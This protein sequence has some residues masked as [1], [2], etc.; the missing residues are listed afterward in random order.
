MAGET[1]G[2]WLGK[3]PFTLTM[4]SGFFGFYAH[5]GFVRALLDAG[6]RPAAFTG[7]S[8]GALVAGCIASGLAPSDLARELV[9]IERRDFWDPRPGLGLLA[10]RKF[11]ARL[12]RMLPVARVEACTSPLAVSVF[13]VAT[14]RT[15][16][17]REGHLADTLRASCAVPFLFHPVWLDGRPT[18][19]GGILDRPGLDGV[20]PGARTLMN[21]LTS[22]SPW[23]RAAPQSM[24]VPR[25]EGLTVLAIEGLP[26]SGPT[27]L[28]AGRAALKR[29]E[30]AA[31][32][33][34]GAPVEA[35]VRVKA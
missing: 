22:R 14:R 29:A 12:E 25:R 13:D 5:T 6:L 34:L 27:R 20:A 8:A 23:R 30:E 18:L 16:V 21:H 32:R 35:L 31:K 2:D 3:A 15:R 26:R 7:S 28:D 9:A 33:A 11:R 10:G 17:V 19:D 4:S 1:L 24:E